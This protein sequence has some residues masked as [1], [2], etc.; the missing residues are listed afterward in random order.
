MIIKGLNNYVYLKEDTHEYFDR[1]GRKYESVSKF[2]ERFKKPFDPMIAYSCAGK[3]DYVGMTGEQVVEQW[4]NYKNERAG[5]GTQIHNAME[6]FEKTAMV[7]PEDEALRPGI[8]SIASEYNG[9]Y[10]ILQEQ[11]VYDTD[12]MIAGT[13]DKILVTSSHHTA[14]L[15]LADY[16][17][18]LG[19]IP[20]KDFDKKGKPVH[21]YW[22]APLEHLLYSK[23]SDYAVQLSIYAYLLE[24]QTGRKIGSLRIHVLNTESPLE[25]Y[26]LPVPYMKESVIAMLEWKKNP[27]L[28]T[29]VT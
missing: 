22:L 9:Y 14:I 7:L 5:I 27:H 10:K 28:H 25:H 15:D 16:K 4:E 18:N 24:K 23:Y 29:I 20:V 8:L 11:V 19:G 6:R 1:D 2:R 17:S 12:Y 21:K 3:G 13:I 26:F